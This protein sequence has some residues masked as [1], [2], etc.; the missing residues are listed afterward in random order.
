M[1]LVSQTAFLNETVIIRASLGTSG[2][3]LASSHLMGQEPISNHQAEAGQSASEGPTLLQDSG[4]ECVLF[5]PVSLTGTKIDS[6][7]CDLYWK[8]KRI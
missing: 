5:M 6:M 1:I 8:Y 4:R 3:S 7:N 2:S